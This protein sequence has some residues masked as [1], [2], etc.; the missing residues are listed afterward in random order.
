[1]LL[2]LWA[3]KLGSVLSFT[4]LAAQPELIKPNFKAQLSIPVLIFSQILIIS[5]QIWIKH[6]VWHSTNFEE[7]LN[8]IC[9]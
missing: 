7:Q 5:N 3:A 6:N 4:N 2:D 1:M 9:T 8:C